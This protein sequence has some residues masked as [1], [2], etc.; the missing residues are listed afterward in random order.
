MNDVVSRCR[1]WSVLIQALFQSV[2]MLRFFLLSSPKQTHVGLLGV[3][4]RIKDLVKK[5]IFFQAPHLEKWWKHQIESTQ[6]SQSFVWHLK[7]NTGWSAGH[8][9]ESVG[10]LQGS[11]CGGVLRWMWLPDTVMKS[12]PD[13]HTLVLGGGRVNRFMRTGLLLASVC[14]NMWD[15]EWYARRL[16]HPETTS[17][18]LLAPTVCLLHYILQILSARTAPR[19]HFISTLHRI[20]SSGLL[21]TNTYLCHEEFWCSAQQKQRKFT[22]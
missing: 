2:S 14:V 9:P 5:E 15:I 13:V 16:V 6:S 3:S 19:Q 7:G 17:S 11:T 10:T 21:F 8:H 20:H 22:F 1:C 12:L 18:E 4:K